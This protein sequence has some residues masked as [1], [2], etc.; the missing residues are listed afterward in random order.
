MAEKGARAKLYDVAFRMY[1]EGQSL[2]EIE[3]ALG[4]SRQTLSSWKA[5]TKR[6]S[7]EQDAWD[8]ARELK[9]SAVRRV[10]DLYED[11]LKYVEETAACNRD[12]RMIDALAKL[13]ALVERA[14]KIAASAR[15]Q[16]LEE[17][18]EAVG[19]TAKQAGVSEETIAIIRRDVLRMAS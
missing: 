12:A 10:N 14:E 3:A 18:A 2:T 13:G 4:V 6:P 16:A 9:R 1:A 19:A 5:D 17:A 11:Q 15:R 8:K 7:E